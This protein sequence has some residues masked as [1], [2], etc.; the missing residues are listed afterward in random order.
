MNLSVW[1]DALPAYERVFYCCAIPATVILLLHVTLTFF[2][3]GGDIDGDMEIDGDLGGEEDINS[4]GL[5]LFTLRNFEAFFAM[6]GWGGLLGVE[7]GLSIWLSS[8]LGVALG[9]GSAIG[10]AFLMRVIYNLQRSGTSNQKSVIGKKAT[11]YMAIPEKG[12]GFG[13]INV[14]ID[15]I[16]RERKAMSSGEAISTGTEV[17]IISYFNNI[18]TVERSL[19]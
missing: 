11:V 8:A 13:K 14:E 18:F 5:P 6:F 12:S 1:W 4:T 17:L 15:G 2:G 19:A 10:M 3:L 9:S 7:N 16:I